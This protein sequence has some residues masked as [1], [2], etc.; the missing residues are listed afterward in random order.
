MHLSKFIELYTEKRLYK[1][2]LNTSDLKI[3]NSSGCY[4]DNKLVED[5]RESQETVR[6][7]AVGKIRYDE[8]LN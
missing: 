8:D 7:A 2:N 4:M 3:K 1:S 5:R 6:R